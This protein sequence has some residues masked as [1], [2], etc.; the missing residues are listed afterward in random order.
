MQD[1][2]I[3]GPFSEA[4]PD[5]TSSN[6][7]EV[8]EKFKIENK[9]FEGVEEIEFSPSTQQHVTSLLQEHCGYDFLENLRIKNFRRFANF[10]IVRLKGLESVFNDMTLFDKV[11]S[12]SGVEDEHLENMKIQ[13]DELHQAA[14]RA[15]D[16][17][18]DQ[19]CFMIW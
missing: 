13:V 15:I 5:F 19:A 16:T 11:S 4:N 9:K 17:H 18:G 14:M 3:F 2:V 10:K 1:K 12:I 7:K 6:D 8:F